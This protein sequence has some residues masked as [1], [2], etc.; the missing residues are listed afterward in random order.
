MK[1][2][3]FGIEIELTGITRYQAA[4]TIAAYFGTS[5][6]NS[7]GTY[8]VPDNQGRTWLVVRDGSITAQKKVNGVRMFAN[9]DERQVEVVSPKC[10]YEDIETIQE[11]VRRLRKGG[12]FVN[13]SCGIHIHVDAANH[14]AK[15]LRNLLNLMASKEDMLYKALHVDLERMR[16]YCQKVNGSLVEDINRTKPATMEALKKLWYKP[17]SGG[18][19][20]HYHKSRYHGLNFHSVFTKGT[21]EFRLFNSTTHAG[22]IKAYIQLCLAI[23][24]QAIA[25]R[26]ASARKT[27][28]TNE[29]FTFRTWLLRLGLI[30]DEF[31]TARQ[32]LLEK[33]EGNSAW[34]YAAS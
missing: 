21:V 2:Q 1:N 25:Q 28:T 11:L 18:T 24:H 30:G 27:A 17:Y 12:A 7:Y 10:R 34:R 26:G 22:K 8:K 19:N 31:K 29:K 20:I 13:S 15:T 9:D 3:Y 6:N 33:L 32:H 23:S 14:N 4:T 5:S 16:K